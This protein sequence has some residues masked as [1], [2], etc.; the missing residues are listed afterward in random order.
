MKKHTDNTDWK[1]RRKRRLKQ[2]N[3]ALLALFTLEVLLTIMIVHEI[4]VRSLLRPRDTRSVG[5]ASMS[6]SDRT[7][8]NKSFYPFGGA[9]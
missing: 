8:T 4:R 1:R 6:V 5:L 2:V 7:N 9:A 3:I